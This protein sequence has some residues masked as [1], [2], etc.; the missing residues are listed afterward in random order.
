MVDITE[1]APR[2][3]AA[4]TE[5]ATAM[6]CGDYQRAVDGLNRYRGL[7][8]GRGRLA[9]AFWIEPVKEKGLFSQVQSMALQLLEML[10]FQHP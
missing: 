9:E 1:Q 4:L 10:R 2:K 6:L 5:H 8:L 3:Q 7:Y